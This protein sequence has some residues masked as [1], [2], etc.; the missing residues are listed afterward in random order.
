M[1]MRV[2]FA[3]QVRVEVDGAAVDLAPLG[4][5]GRLFWA[6]LACERHRPVPKNE[7]AEVL[8]GEDELP[9]PC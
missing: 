6:Y 4:R 1:A 8:W 9:R 2:T 3:G 7:L 5:T